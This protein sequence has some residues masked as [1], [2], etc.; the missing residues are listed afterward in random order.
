MY[1]KSITNS[2]SADRS[3]G[4]SNIKTLSEFYQ[5]SLLFTSKFQDVLTENK[6]ENIYVAVE[7]QQ[8]NG[9]TERKWRV[10]E[11]TGGSYPRTQNW[12]TR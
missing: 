4:T 6:K 12:E 3:E 8:R 10:D 11:E 7:K 5:I 1:Q 2:S 9:K